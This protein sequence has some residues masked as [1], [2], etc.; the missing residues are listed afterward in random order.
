MT[1]TVFLSGSRKIGRLN[2]L[3]RHRL[4]NMLD[5][6]FH[7][8]VGDANGADRAFQGYLAEKGYQDVSVFCSGSSCRNNVGQ[9][10]VRSVQVDPKL[11]G[12]AFY[13][14]KDKEM[15]AEADYGFVIWDGKSEGSINNIFEL[16]KKGKKAV[17]YLSRS[18]SFRNI[19]SAKDIEDLLEES[20]ISISHR[21]GGSS[22]ID[23]HLNDFRLS[24]QGSFNL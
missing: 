24:Q 12:R 3:V 6:E 22:L 1:K 14:Q 13:T 19:K 15:A 2:D 18:K 23:Q 7:V 17:V 16:L 9:W 5:Q 21:S 20:E 10:S 8:I 4:Q 11:K